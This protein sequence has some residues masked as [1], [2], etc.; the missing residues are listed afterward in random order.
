LGII[1]RINSYK[2]FERHM[3]QHGSNCPKPILTCP[4]RQ[5]V[6]QAAEEICGAANVRSDILQDSDLDEEG[7]YWT[8][9][10][11][12]VLN[13]ILGDEENLKDRSQ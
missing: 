2:I 4:N 3:C 9:E 13:E 8:Q 1:R 10:N 5:I 7:N 12:Q 11:N 6:R